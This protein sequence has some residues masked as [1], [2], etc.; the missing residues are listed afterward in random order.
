VSQVPFVTPMSVGDDVP[1]R[2]EDGL[3]PTVMFLRVFISGTG[4]YVVLELR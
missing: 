3:L 2:A 1:K 4:H